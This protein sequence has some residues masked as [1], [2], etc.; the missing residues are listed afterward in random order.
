MRRHQVEAYFTPQNVFDLPSYRAT[1][2]HESSDEE[3][4][5][6]L[7]VEGAGDNSSQEPMAAADED[8]EGEDFD[9]GV[10]RDRRA[11]RV[12]DTPLA[13][14]CGQLPH[15]RRLEFFITLQTRSMLEITRLAT[16]RST[17]PNRRNV[18]RVAL[19]MIFH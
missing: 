12:L 11:A 5:G 18:F 15:G 2:H 7:L 17:R 19:T 1:E 4:R 6:T 13:S 14:H 10:V 3:K 16:Y 9:C 8:L